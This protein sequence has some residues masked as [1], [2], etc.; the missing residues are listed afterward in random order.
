MVVHSASSEEQQRNTTSS[1]VRH[2]VVE[3]N[4]FQLIP[5]DRISGTVF[6]VPDE[7]DYNTNIIE[8]ILVVKDMEQWSTLFFD[9]EEY[10]KNV[11]NRG[12]D[13][14]VFSWDEIE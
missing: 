3:K 12:F 8:S 6:A 11:N 7:I 2:F 9:Y 13:A 14:N 1:I 10:S 4:K 5:A